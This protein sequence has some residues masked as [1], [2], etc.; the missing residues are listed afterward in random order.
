M[1]KP[2]SQGIDPARVRSWLQSLCA[3]S[4]GS[5]TPVSADEAA[6]LLA[7]THGRSGK[8]FAELA[9]DRATP[10]ADLYSAKN[11]TLDLSIDASLLWSRDLYEQQLPLVAE[12]IESSQPTR[13]I[14]FG[15][16]QGLVTCFAALAAPTAKVLGLDPC[17]EAIERARE[18]AAKLG[19]SNVEFVVADLIGDAVLAHEV[20]PADLLMTSRA[21]LGEAIDDGSDRPSELL[22]GVTPADPRWALEASEAARCLA[23]LALPNAPLC[24]IERTGT[25]GLVRWSAA[26]SDAG[27]E[28]SAPARRLPAPEP[29]NPDQAFRVV[30]ATFRAKP[31]AAPPTWQLLGC[32]DNPLV[33]GEWSEEAAERVALSSQI[34]ET[35]GA[36]QWLNSVGETE[37]VELAELTN[38]LLLELRCSTNGARHVRIQSSADPAVECARL[39]RAAQASA[40]HSIPSAKPLLDRRDVAAT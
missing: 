23:S 39:A 21:V 20:V 18:L 5:A 16:E 19:L 38:G 29:G 37:H 1:N 25:T 2:S 14:D 30:H 7:A 34:Q 17:A 9:L 13:V 24:D 40:G 33:T 12:L 31:C 27:F 26:L 11:A 8:R 28:L 4:D 15:C 36:W 6:G 32:A 22:A 35:L 3:V 10:R